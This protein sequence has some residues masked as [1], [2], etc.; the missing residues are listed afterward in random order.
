VGEP[1][2]AALPPR[3]TAGEIGVYNQPVVVRTMTKD[4][5]WTPEEIAERIDQGLGA[6]RLPILD[7]LDTM[8][9]AAAKRKGAS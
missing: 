4:E 2:A 1:G 3:S 5:R 7:M 9:A 6:E 8:A